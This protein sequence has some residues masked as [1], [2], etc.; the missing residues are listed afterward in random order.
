LPPSFVLLGFIPLFVRPDSA[1]ATSRHRLLQHLMIGFFFLTYFTRTATTS[2]WRAG[3]A[4][5]FAPVPA[6][7]L[8][9]TRYCRQR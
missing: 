8:Y 5:L 9:Q 2:C 6:A 7:V 1:L 4:G 3:R